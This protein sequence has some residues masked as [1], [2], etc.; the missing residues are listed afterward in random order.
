MQKEATLFLHKQMCVFSKILSF[1]TLY[2]FIDFYNSFAKLISWNVKKT[3]MD[4]W[5][6]LYLHYKTVIIILF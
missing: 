4:I 6:I 3:A 5:N 2:L 1:K